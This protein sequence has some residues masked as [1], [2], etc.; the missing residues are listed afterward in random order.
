VVTL[1]S[2]AAANARALLFIIRRIM[3]MAEVCNLGV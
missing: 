1:R 2:T 3:Q